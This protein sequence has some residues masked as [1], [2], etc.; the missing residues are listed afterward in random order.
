MHPQE[1]SQK[2]SLLKFHTKYS[3]SCIVVKNADYVLNNLFNE[4]IIINVHIDS[5]LDN[6]ATVLCTSC[7]D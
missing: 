2:W 3:S 4:T 5:F 6:L 7:Y 1:R